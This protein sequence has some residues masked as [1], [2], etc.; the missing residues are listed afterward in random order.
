MLYGDVELINEIIKF[1]EDKIPFIS[2]IRI[3]YPRFYPINN[4][5][6]YSK[7]YLVPLESIKKFIKD[8]K[9]KKVVFEN[10]PLCILN[11]N[12]AKKINWNIKLIKHAKVIK[13]LEGRA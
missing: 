3:S 8:I 10:I 9:G 4:R 13:G 6:E 2:E 5:K 7:K 12:R 1:I 11:D